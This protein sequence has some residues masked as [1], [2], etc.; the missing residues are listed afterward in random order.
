[1][2]NNWIKELKVGDEVI[3]ESCGWGHRRS[4]EKVEKIN[5][6]TIK[7]GGSLFSIDSGYERGDGWHNAT[8]NQC[9]TQAK[10]ELRIKQEKD[11]I[12]ARLFVFPW[13]RLSYEKLL[14]VYNIVKEDE[15]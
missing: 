2:D 8:L 11:R 13:S 7:V 15:K 1:M 3:V 14:K 4:I 10:E 6:V 5:K 9:T 12:A